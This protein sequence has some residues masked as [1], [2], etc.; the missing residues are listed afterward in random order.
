M[1]SRRKVIQRV[2]EGAVFVGG[3]GLIGG[4][5]SKQTPRLTMCFVLLVL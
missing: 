4:N 2:L 1:V 5:P 3:G